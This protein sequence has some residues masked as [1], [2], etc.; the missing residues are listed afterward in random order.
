MLTNDESMVGFNEKYGSNTSTL[1]KAETPLNE[2]KRKI[3][4]YDENGRVSARKRDFDPCKE[5]N[6]S[7]KEMWELGQKVALKV[8]CLEEDADPK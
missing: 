1:V 8:D 6:L 4:V 7:R 5:L 2:K 3:L